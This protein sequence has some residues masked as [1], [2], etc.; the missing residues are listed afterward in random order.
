MISG[1]IR[2]SWT[3]FSWRCGLYSGLFKNYVIDQA[4][5]AAKRVSTLF[6]NIFLQ[7]GVHINLTFLFTKWI[8]ITNH[9]SENLNVVLVSGHP[10]KYVIQKLLFLYFQILVTL[11]ENCK[12]IRFF[13]TSCA[14]FNTFSFVCIFWCSSRQKFPPHIWDTAVNYTSDICCKPVQINTLHRI[15]H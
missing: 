10:Q 11:R 1:Q 14:L 13:Y 15:S 2:F 3:S 9:N 8:Q 12:K 5:F 4:S 6:T 7:Y